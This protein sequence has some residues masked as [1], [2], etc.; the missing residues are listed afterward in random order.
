MLGSDENRRTIKTVTS[1]VVDEYDRKVYGRF[2]REVRTG[3]DVTLPSPRSKDPGTRMVAGRVMYSAAWL[4]AP[5]ASPDLRDLE[6]GEV[7]V[8]AAEPRPLPS[9]HRVT[10]S[11]MALRARALAGRKVIRENPDLDLLDRLEL[12]ALVLWPSP[13]LLAYYEIG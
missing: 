2:V 13:K 11:E 1:I 7:E 12:L 5:E 9:P 10:D 3:H 4:D 8:H 6:P